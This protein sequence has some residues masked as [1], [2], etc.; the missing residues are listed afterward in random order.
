MNPIF[1]IIFMTNTV[2]ILNN[3]FYFL[4]LFKFSVKEK[5][6]IFNIKIMFFFYEKNIFNIIKYFYIKYLNIYIFKYF[7]YIFFIKIVLFIICYLFVL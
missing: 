1:V 2:S 5:Y 6:Y 7:I 4:E 3:Y